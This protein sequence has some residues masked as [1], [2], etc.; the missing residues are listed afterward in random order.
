MKLKIIP[1]P[2]KE[3]Y[4]EITLAVKNNNGFCPCMS[5]QTEDTRCI[6]KAFRE[7]NSVGECH[8]GR[9]YKIEDTT[10]K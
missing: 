6:C 4:D 9:F 10:I 5:E 8:C 2:D 7:C 3:I 1:N